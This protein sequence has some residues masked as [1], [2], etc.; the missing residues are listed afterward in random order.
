MAALPDEQ[1]VTPLQGRFKLMEDI[2]RLELE[3]GHVLPGSAIP[4]GVADLS[5]GSNARKSLYM[6]QG[7]SVAGL[8]AHLRQVEGEYIIVDA[9][10]EAGTWVNCRAV[11]AEGARLQHG[12]LV[13]IGLETFRFELNHPQPPPE[14]HVTAW[15]E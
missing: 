11:P 14:V 5:I 4:L 10:S 1:Q 13:Q 3:S 15:E 8:H 7:A 6:L 2:F 12:D 9:G